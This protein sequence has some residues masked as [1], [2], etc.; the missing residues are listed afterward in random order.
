MRLLR[1][2]QAAL[3]Q[4]RAPHPN[5]Q[6][7][8]H[9]GKLRRWN[10]IT[11]IGEVNHMADAVELRARLDFRQRALTRLRDAYIKLIEGGVKSYMIDDRQLT[12][13]DLPALKKEIE[14][15][16]DEID[17]L[18]AALANTRPRKAFGVIPRDW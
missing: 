11:T 17:E 8:R 15:L 1:A 14:A 6:G 13:F 2:A 18:E 9:G 16:E 4:R 7:N 3:Q 10:D 5:Q 12:K